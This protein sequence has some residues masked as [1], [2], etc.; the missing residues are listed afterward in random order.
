MQLGWVHHVLGIFWKV[1]SYS[2]RQNCRKIDQVV[3]PSIVT[4]ILSRPGVNNVRIFFANGFKLNFS[5][6]IMLIVWVDGNFIEERRLVLIYMFVKNEVRNVFTAKIIYFRNK[7]SVKQ[8]FLCYLYTWS[9]ISKVFMSEYDYWL[10]SRVFNIN[11][12]IFSNFEVSTCKPWTD[13][14]SSWKHVYI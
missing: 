4:I 14:D 7:G 10:L 3:H 8:V 11:R 1:G 5:I 9:Y 12:S 6:I 2:R 13:H